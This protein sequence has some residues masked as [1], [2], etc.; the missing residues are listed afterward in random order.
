MDGE[1]RSL[2]YTLHVYV[3]TVDIV[4]WKCTIAGPGCWNG[5]VVKVRS[6]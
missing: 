6:T 1:V 3:N 5:T 2:V 4:F